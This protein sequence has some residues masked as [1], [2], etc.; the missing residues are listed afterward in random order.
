MFP[1]F[2]CDS[3]NLNN[4]KSKAMIKYLMVEIKLHQDVTS[5]NK[6]NEIMKSIYSY[7]YLTFKISLYK[8]NFKFIS[9]KLIEGQNGQENFDFMIVSFDR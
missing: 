7:C 1:P 5:L 4:D 3:V 8:D 2:S 9:E 6:V